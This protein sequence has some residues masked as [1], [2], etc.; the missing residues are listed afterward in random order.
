MLLSAEQ[1]TSAIAEVLLSK[2]FDGLDRKALL[3]SALER[4]SLSSTEVGHSVALAHAKLRSIRKV[5]AALGIKPEGLLY[6]D[7]RRV[8]FLFVIATSYADSLLYMEFLRKVLVFMHDDLFDKELLDWALDQDK[9]QSPRLKA[10]LK[11]LAFYE[12]A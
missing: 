9:P 7:G 10:F 1:R 11:V 2:A 3:A 8:T 4:E 12:K 6:P 5:H